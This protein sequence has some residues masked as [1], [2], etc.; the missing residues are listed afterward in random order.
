VNSIA[1]N[2]QKIEG[3]IIT[4]GDFDT[5]TTGGRYGMVGTPI[6][7]PVA[8]E[9]YMEVLVDGARIMQTVTTPTSDIYV[10]V[11]DTSWSAWNANDNLTGAEI[12]SLYE[13]EADTNAYTDAEKATVSTV[14]N[15]GTTASRPVS[16]TTGQM[17]FDTDLGTTG[18]PIWYDSTQWVDATGTAV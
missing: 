4:D 7:G 14:N 11:F 16:P 10:R 9:A 17:Y 2:L 3:T 5:V 1:S 13:A 12:K 18:K 6:N 15:S 8:G